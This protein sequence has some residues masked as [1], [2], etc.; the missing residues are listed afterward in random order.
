M[1]N[2]SASKAH[3]HAFSVMCYNRTTIFCTWFELARSNVW[4]KWQIKSRASSIYLAQK[5]QGRPLILDEQSQYDDHQCWHIW[6]GSYRKISR[7]MSTSR[8]IFCPCPL[9]D[10]L[11]YSKLVRCTWLHFCGIG[12]Q[13][14]GKIEAWFPILEESWAVI[15][16]SINDFDSTWSREQ[17]EHPHVDPTQA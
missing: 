7:H 11:K 17:A 12:C 14:S 3:Y 10:T 9:S 8:M 13:Y 2:P 16:M 1:Q 5:E 6:D 15:K 4:I